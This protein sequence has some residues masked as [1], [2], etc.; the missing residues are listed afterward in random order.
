MKSNLP[1]PKRLT[2]N[3]QKVIE[4]AFNF[5]HSIVAGDYH[6]PKPMNY[7]TNNLQDAVWDLANERGISIEDGCSKEYLG[8][9]NGYMDG[10]LDN[11]R[12]RV[13]EDNG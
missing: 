3:E 6:L 10:V 13:G 9:Y 7:T 4:W 1:T 5:A 8:V 11:I 12:K 2:D